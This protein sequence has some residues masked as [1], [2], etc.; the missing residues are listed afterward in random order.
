MDNETNNLLVQVAQLNIKHIKEIINNLKEHFKAIL[1]DQII[2]EN[3]Y[4]E[5]NDKLKK[6]L[7]EISIVDKKLLKIIEENEYG[8]DYE[9]KILLLEVKKDTTNL[10]TNLSSIIYEYGYTTLSGIFEVILPI[11][12]YSEYKNEIN[13]KINFIDKYFQIKNIT[14]I[15]ITSYKQVNMKLKEIQQIKLKTNKDKDKDSKELK[16]TEETEKIQV[17]LI[18]ELN[19]ASIELEIDDICLIIYGYFKEDTINQIYRDTIFESKY[20]KVLLEFIKTYR[21]EKNDKSDSSMNNAKIFCKEYMM[22]YSVKD[23]ILKDIKEIVSDININL[24]LHNKISRQNIVELLNKFIDDDLYQKRNIISLLLMD[25][26]DENIQEFDEIEEL[27]IYESN[28][29][30]S[31]KKYKPNFLLIQSKNEYILDEDIDKLTEDE[32]NSN[33]R[34][35]K[36][37]ED[38]VKDKDFDKED[39]KENIKNLLPKLNKTTATRYSISSLMKNFDSKNEIKSFNKI[40]YNSKKLLNANVLVDFLRNNMLNQIEYNNFKKSIHYLLRRRIFAKESNETK[41]IK[42]KEE[43]TYEMKLDLINVSDKSKQKV[44]EKI[45]ELR[46]SKENAKAETYIEGFFKIPF[47]NYVK[48]DIFIH[49]DKIS[50][51]INNLLKKINSHIA[52]QDSQIKLNDSIN[53]IIEKTKSISEIK[54]YPEQLI[55]E[56]QNLIEI[57]TNYLNKVDTILESAIYGHKDSKREMKRIIAQWMGG[58][59]M[60]GTILGFHGPPGVGKTVFAQKGIGKC[61]VDSDGNTRPFCIFQLGGASDGAVLEGHN[62]TYVGAKWGRLVEM[63]MD[64]K[65]MN[66][67]IY[68]DELDKISNTDKGREIIDILIHITD[69]SQ[70][71]EIYDRYFSGVE[72]DFSKCIIIFSYNDVS[73]VDRILRDRITEIKINP[74]KKKEKV[75]ITQKYTLKEIS[76]SINNTCELDESLIEYI[77]DT[78]TLEPGVRK[79]NEKLYEIFREVNLR[80]LENPN[81]NLEINKDVIDEILTRHYKVRHYQI[82]K[83]PEI[84]LINGLYASSVGLG[85]ITL[86]QV[87]K[88]ITSATNLPLELTGQQGDV[89]KESMSCAKTL[90]LR[91]LNFEEKNNLNKELKEIP[92]GLHIH[93]P[94]TSTPKDGP[95]A[96]ITITTGIYSL[97]TGRPIRNDIAMTGEVDLLGNVKAIGGLDAK[98]N[99]AIKAGVKK[100]L[101]PKENEQDYIKILEAKSLD[102]DIE[103]VMVDNIQEVISHAIL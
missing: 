97:L 72:L 22:Q 11:E 103:C 63:L 57:K 74:L 13:R 48:E 82:H 18:Y 81:E 38:S 26:S 89:M 61:L 52:I 53:K 56:K 73:K 10:R 23:F 1:S 90:A 66:P 36:D 99:G 30:E 9:N 76:D 14:K 75:V 68:F 37:S 21:L 31:P 102:G 12:I 41:Q 24:S 29:L 7:N 87:L 45:K 96:G 54:N 71:K 19:K 50:E 70:N 27:E 98:I 95:S 69:K 58:G 49:C 33:L 101:F 85:G 64:T 34:N 39:I 78:Y 15:P 4:F 3:L 20:K 84:G 47:G 77:I 55:R 65:C 46:T 59:K 35:R 17:N 93:C 28:S 2:S 91:L 100:V 51:N 32:L 42:L 8:L 79:L 83:K 80:N 94:D 43:L 40:I 25:E 44:Q 60:D 67:I 6:Y 5:L 16:E 62:Y 88:S 86:I 92:F